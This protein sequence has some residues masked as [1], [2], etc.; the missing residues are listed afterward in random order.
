M[1][2]PTLIEDTQIDEHEIGFGT[3]MSTKS[4]S[5]CFDIGLDNDEGEAPLQSLRLLLDGGHDFLGAVQP[6]LGA[7]LEHELEQR[8]DAVFRLESG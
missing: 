1:S 6:L 4:I 2:T 8:L 5:E 3:E 7:S